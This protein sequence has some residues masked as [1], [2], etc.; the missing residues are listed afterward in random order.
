MTRN[1]NDPRLDKTLVACLDLYFE[2]LGDQ[3]PH[4]VYEMVQ[5]AIEPPLLKYA[6]SRCQGNLSKTASLLGLS[7]N[8]LRKKLAQYRIAASET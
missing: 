7:R 1:D 6:L 4:P 8:T 5:Q 3:K 2:Q